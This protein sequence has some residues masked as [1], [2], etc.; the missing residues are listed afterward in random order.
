M[1]ARLET[2]RTHQIRAHF[3][4]I[5][6]PLAGDRD[7]GGAAA[8]G[9]RRQFLHSARLAFRYS[10]EPAP[11]EEAASAASADLSRRAPARRRN[12]RKLRWSPSNSP[13]RR[14]RSLP[15]ALRAGSRGL[16]GRFS[17]RFN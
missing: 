11:V 2:G 1:R 8:L 7:Y 3:A 13:V 9:L 5:G 14:P 4:A 15:G 16:A 10:G 17:K 6:H 12:S